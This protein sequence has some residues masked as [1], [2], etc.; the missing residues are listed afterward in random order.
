MVSDMKIE[1]RR[2][3]QA[4]GIAG[5]SVLTPMSYRDVEAQQGEFAPFD[6]PYFMMIN[7]LGGWDTTRF[8]DPKG[9]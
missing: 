3:L 7:C 5:L 1:R 9:L 6:G 2:F 8:L 4:A